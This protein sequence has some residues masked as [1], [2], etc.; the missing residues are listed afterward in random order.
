VKKSFCA[1]IHGVPL[2]N[3]SEVT[4]EQLARVRKA[5]AETV[6]IYMDEA[7]RAAPGSWAPRLRALLE[8]AGLT[9]AYLGG[10]AARLLS[11]NNIAR[12]SEVAA[13][14]TGID[15]VASVGAG[16]LLIGPGGFAADGPWWYHPRNYEPAS[17]AALV[18]SLR[19]LGKRAES[20]GVH[21]LIEGHQMSVLESPDV[22]RSVLEE[23]GSTAV[24]ANFD[25]VNFLTPPR[26]ARFAET[27][28]SMAAALG[29]WMVAVHVKDAVLGPRLSV[30]IDEAPAG[31]G[32][33]ELAA[34]V[35]TAARA[36]VPALVEHL[37]DV[38]ADEAL[39]HL[40]ALV[41]TERKA[42]H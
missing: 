12:Q 6:G 17:R 7:E 1:G 8:D 19:E 41:D 14:A 15:A 39:R 3:V 33:L 20:I 28:Q 29:D 42:R 18:N 27:V 13:A 32:A 25:P 34:V 9:C 16:G 24:G 11:H 22:I 36:G 26:M 2:A 10:P 5:G 23:A 30:H 21:I 40:A 31:R 35:S 4:A 38:D 37:N